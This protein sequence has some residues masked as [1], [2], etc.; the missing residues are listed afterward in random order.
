MMEEMFNRRIWKKWKLI[1]CT[2]DY[3]RRI[4]VQDIQDFRLFKSFQKKSF[5][6]AKDLT[7]IKNRINTMSDYSA[8]FV[9][10]ESELPPLS[11]FFLRS[12]STPRSPK[13]AFSTLF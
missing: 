6:F 12:A 13:V 11:I 10:S 8:G 4:A 1:G 7:M 9:P 2:D 5:A 3:Y